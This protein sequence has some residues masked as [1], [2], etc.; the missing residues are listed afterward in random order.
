VA[1][2]RGIIRG[3]RGEASRLGS[4]ASGLDVQAASWQGKVTVHLWEKNG[5]DMALV[6]LDQ[7]HGKGTTRTLYNGPVSGCAG[8]GC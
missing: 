7:H 8:E 1:H 3:Q 4:K 5:V 6:E 2:F